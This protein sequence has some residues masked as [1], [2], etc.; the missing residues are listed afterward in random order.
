MNRLKPFCSIA[1]LALALLASAPALL[2]QEQTPEVLVPA[3]ASDPVRSTPSLELDPALQRIIDQDNQAQAQADLW[4]REHQELNKEKPFQDD[5]LP[6]RIRDRLASVEKAYEDY[7]FGHPESMEGRLA[8]ASFLM[9]IGRDNDAAREWLRLKEKHPDS[10]VLLNNL[11]NYF[12]QKGEAL[13]AFPYY[14]AAIAKAPQEPLYVKN[15]ASVVYIF[16]E[17]AFT[18]YHLK[19]QAALLLAQALYRKAL[20]LAPDDFIL[21]T[22]LAQ[23]W[24]YLSPFKPEKALADWKKAHALAADDSERQAVLLH[25]ARVAILAGDFEEAQKQ[26]EAVTFPQHQE[27]KETLLKNLDERRKLAEASNPEAP[28]P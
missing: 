19:P 26:L 13:E 24:Y 8:Y 22:A 18:Y 17:E 11:G 10:P 5:T 15:L 20:L 27:L 3:P 6:L 16:R 23:T 14:E 12:A 25:Y 21:R 2:A 1:L 28:T 4:I 9:D 7:L